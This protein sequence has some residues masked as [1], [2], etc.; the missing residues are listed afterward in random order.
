MADTAPSTDLLRRV[1][2][3][4]LRDLLRGR[5]SGRLD[6]RAV[7]A[8]SGLPSVVRAAVHT[9]VRHTRLWRTE[10]VDVAEELLAHFADGVAAGFPAEQLVQ[11][12]GDP[13]AAAKL[14]RRGKVR[15][16]PWVWHVLRGLGAAAAVLVLFYA[17]L[18]IY[19]YAGRPSIRVNYVARLNQSI[20]QTPLSRRA[21]PV[22]RDVLVT[23]PNLW[24]L[25]VCRY[26][27]D[28]RHWPAMADWLRAH[29]DVVARIRSASALPALG[30]VLGA[31]G[32]VNDPALFDE[33][34]RRG[35][36]DNTS[37]FL[38]STLLPELNPLRTLAIIVADDAKLACEQQDGRRFQADVVELD[39]LAAQL[40]GGFLVSDFVSLGVQSLAYGTMAQSLARSPELLSDA[41]LRDLAHWFSLP[42][43]AADFIDLSDEQAGFEDFVQRA[44]TDDGHGSGRLTWRGLHLLSGIN[45]QPATDLP[46]GISDPATMSAEAI[47]PALALLGASRAQLLRQYDALIDELNQRMRQ[48]LRDVKPG[49]KEREITRPQGRV[50]MIRFGF[51]LT[52]P[53]LPLQKLAEVPERALGQRDGLLVGI[54]LE[55]FR[56]HHGHYPQQLDELVPALLPRVPDDRITGDPVKYRL[57]DGKPVVYSVGVDRID[58]G[59]RPAQVGDVPDAMRAARW[60]KPDPMVRGDWVLYPPLIHTYK[61]SDE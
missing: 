37:G 48:P 35:A 16:R 22:Y 42:Q 24:Q 50:D 51:L 41:E 31:N 56:R 28:G 19:F 12:F 54:S 45:G 60:D 52:A 21:W 43:V 44:Y 46:P 58:D 34:T 29:Q 38:L 14:I 18:A 53:P 47:T 6:W 57:I 36:A 2:T 10:K 5:L 55:V 23:L 20:E 15:N 9:V 30:F 17:G 25:P 27:R 26:D 49:P 11:E 39:A 4:P 1:R 40:R 13:R 8:A 61:E 32:S 3:T 33:Y 59:G 7:I